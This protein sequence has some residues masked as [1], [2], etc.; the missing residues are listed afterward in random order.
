[1][2]VLFILKV[3][4]FMQVYKLYSVVNYD[5]ICSYYIPAIYILIYLF[6]IIAGYPVPTVG[7]PCLYLRQTC[8]ERG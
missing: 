7:Y 5:S 6:I 2:H 8:N 1:M 4:L 3:R